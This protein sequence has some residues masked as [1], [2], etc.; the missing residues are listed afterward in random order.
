MDPSHEEA[1]SERRRIMS[2]VVE[3]ADYLRDDRECTNDEVMRV[4]QIDELVCR[5]LGIDPQTAPPYS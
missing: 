1:L 2:E 5:A 3:L 4:G